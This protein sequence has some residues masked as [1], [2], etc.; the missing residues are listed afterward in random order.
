LE[1]TSDEQARKELDTNFWG[2]VDITKHAMRIMRE[3]NPKTG[4]QGGV[5]VQISSMGGYI[6]FPGGAFYHASKFALEGFTEAVAREVHPNW[7]SE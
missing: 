4:Q 5:I 6:G 3:E 1:A 7:N 2:A